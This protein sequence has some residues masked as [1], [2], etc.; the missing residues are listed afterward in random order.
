[1]KRISK[2]KKYKIIKEFPLHNIGD[3]FETHD[4]AVWQCVNN[5]GTATNYIPMELEEL[6]KEGYL[7]EVDERW[8]PEYKSS[9]FNFDTWGELRRQIWNDD[10]MDEKAWKFG[11]CF[12]TQEEAEEARDAIAELLA[13]RRDK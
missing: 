11:N 2:M 6:V 10:F 5:T 4:D 7:E 12:K 8:K 3:V 1:M 13:S 9:Y